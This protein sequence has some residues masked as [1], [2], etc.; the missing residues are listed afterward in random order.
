[1][2]PT[3]LLHIGHYFGTLRNWVELQNEYECFY[4]VADCHA[5]TTSFDRTGQ[6]SD[7]VTEMVIDWLGA[8][9]EPDMSTLFL[10]SWVPEHAELF[11][12]LSMIVPLGWLERVPSYK[13]LK[14]TVDGSEHDT[15][16]LLGYPLLQAADILMYR[17]RY[18]PV[19]EDQVAHIELTREIARRF[20]HLYGQEEGF[21]DKVKAIINRMGKRNSERYN[22]LR[23]SYTERGDQKALKQAQDTVNKLQ[24]LPLHERMSL[25]GYLEGQGRIIFPEPAELVSQAPRIPG[26][27]GRKMSK[28]LKNDISLREDSDT[29]RAKIKV[30]TTDPN[31]KRR[32]DK[33]DP[34]L[35]P[36][37]SL[38][39]AASSQEDRDWVWQGCTTAG[40]GCVDCKGRLSE[41]VISFTQTHQQRC[42][43]LNASDKMVRDL[44]K[45]GSEKAREIARDTLDDVSHAIKLYF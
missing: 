13:D 12:L 14:K 42:R 43:D 6:F 39:Q 8:G 11:L 34:N 9:I 33:G 5:L 24:G 21:E 29:I 16:G 7:H 35:C 26:T 38:H 2:R 31:R 23:E 19:G 44:L 32:D 1:M 10:Q 22:S 45:E 18:V 41:S 3:G 27:D 30:M 17:A 25:L 40:I 20:N 28:S 36:V 4:F 15:Y 37:W